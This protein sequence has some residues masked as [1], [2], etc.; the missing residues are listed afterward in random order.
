[1]MDVIYTALVFA[2]F[3]GCLAALVDIIRKAK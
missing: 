2:I 1:M 3:F